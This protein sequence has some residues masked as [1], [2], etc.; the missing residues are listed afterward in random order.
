MQDLG[1]KHAEWYRQTDRFAFKGNRVACRRVGVGHPMLLIHGFPTAGCDYVDVCAGLDA[2]FDMIVPDLLD[3]GHSENPARATWHIHDQ[4][5][6]L[7]ALLASLGITS[8]HIVA[9]DVGDTVGQELVARHNDGALG[10]GIESLV[11]MNGGILPSEHRPRKIQKLLLGPIGPLISQLMREAR[12]TRTLQEIFGPE[13]RPDA[14]AS[15]ALWR[16]ALGVN[17]KQSFARRIR[18]MQDRR[19]NEARWVGALKETELRML[20]I[21]GIEDPIS[22]AHV[23]D[24]IEEQIPRMDV[25][26]LDGIG[27]FPPLEAPGACVEHILNFH[28]LGG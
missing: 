26:R 23:C 1:E 8:V 22:G 12:M 10:F 19:D 20:M 11:L 6:M 3:Y 14:E 5:D 17:G 4:A 16:I 18:Y 15:A 24:A 28:G 25:I 21:N 2:H 27:H 9:H 7:E 13:T